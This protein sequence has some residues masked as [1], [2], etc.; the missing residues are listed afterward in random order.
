M[1]FAAA[2]ARANAA[3]F[4]HVADCTATVDNVLVSGAFRN[5]YLG[6]LGGVVGTAEPS[7]E[8][9]GVDFT[10]AKQG[11]SLRIV[12][13]P[14]AGNRYTVTAV[15]PDGAGVITLRLQRVTAAA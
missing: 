9:N 2:I 1:T 14:H 11:S 8:F 6:A 15:E 7:F 13:G 3:I 12:D 4:R 5:G 10:R